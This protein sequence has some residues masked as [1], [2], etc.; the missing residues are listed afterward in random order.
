MTK[1]P[2]LERIKIVWQ[3]PVMMQ[4]GKSGV[5]EGAV[6]ELD[7]LLKEHKYMKIRILRSALDTGLSKEQLIEKVC[8]RTGAVL[9]GTR[10][11]TAVIYRLKGK[12][13]S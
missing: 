12:K 8:E 7:R 5:S 13:T 1:K 10:G 9:A 6:K 4:I 11:N 2:D 3:D